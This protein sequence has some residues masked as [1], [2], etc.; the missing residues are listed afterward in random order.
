MPL[1]K[2]AE[3]LPETAS[4]V[5]PRSAASNDD[6]SWNGSEFLASLS[7][8]PGYLFIAP[9]QVLFREERA[10]AEVTA[11]RPRVRRSLESCRCEEGSKRFHCWT[12]SGFALHSVAMRRGLRQHSHEEAFNTN[13]DVLGPSKHRGAPCGRAETYSAF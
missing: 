1:F 4:L 9:R 11:R 6:R 3:A 12:A 5:P 10:A 2:T 8:H 7:L 13:P